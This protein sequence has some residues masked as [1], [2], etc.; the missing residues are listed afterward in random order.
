MIQ[1]NPDGRQLW[2]T[3]RFNR[4]ISVVDTSTGHVIKRLSVSDSPHGLTFFPQPGRFSLG[5]NG[6]YR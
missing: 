1:I 3:N 6:V 4:T 2:V 5:H